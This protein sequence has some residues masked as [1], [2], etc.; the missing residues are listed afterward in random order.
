MAGSFDLVW[1]YILEYEN[2][3]NPF[4]ERKERINIWKKYAIIDVQESTEIIEK[5]YSL[6]KKGVL[7]IDSLHIACAIKSGCDYFLTTDDNILKRSK[8]INEINVND[9]I[10]FV[11]EILQ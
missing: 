3:R 5:A 10:G 8:A 11:K 4:Q 6:N 9:P 1:S 2:S 7:K